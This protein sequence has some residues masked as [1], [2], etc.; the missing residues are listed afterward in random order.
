MIEDGG[1][2]P[3]G[4][5]ARDWR[6]YALSGLA[7]VAI[8]AVAALIQSLLY[9]QKVRRP[10]EFLPSSARA[11][12]ALDVRPDSP[13]VVKMREVWPAQDIS[14]LADRAAELS[15]EVVSWTGLQLDM[16][17]DV[18]PW[19]AGEIAA[20]VVPVEDDIALNP[21]SVVV[22]ARTSSLRRA[23]AALDR[24]V[25]PM[26]HDLE[27]KR[28]T[29]RRPGGTIIVWRDSM[30]Q[31]HV[32]YV[33]LDGCV[34]VSASLE[35]VEQCLVAASDPGQR[36]TGTEPFRAS[37]SHLP[38]DSVA[39]AYLD[40]AYAS[41]NAQRLLLALR[42]GWISLLRQI[43]RGTAAERSSSLREGVGAV[44]IA[45][46]PEKDGLRL[47]ASYASADRSPRKPSPT[48]LAGLA[49]LLP[50]DTAAYAL[51]HEPGR[52]L[53]FGHKGARSMLPRQSGRGGGL[54]APFNPLVALSE[55]PDDVMIAMLPAKNDAAELLIA[56]PSAEIAGSAKLLLAS[57]L[58]HSVSSEVAGFFVV[59]SSDAGLQR[60]RQAAGNE[61]HRL[62]PSRGKDCEFEVW[63]QA[64]LLSG[65]DFPL[66]ELLLRGWVADAGGEG[67][68]VLKASPRRLLGGD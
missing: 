37:F 25:K 8:I 19:F 23:R 65:G 32:A 15:K 14:H 36:L 28:F 2:A 58:P 30:R 44:A 29:A 22:I 45:A 1:S 52:F 34:I 68:V 12:I 18:A 49:S 11:A 9:P 35:A 53:S 57:L 66:Q 40:V 20:A 13:A 16:K 21:R 26:A 61:K 41:S 38:E 48:R 24:A 33:V 43:A 67:E 31:D 27:W 39:W 46:A 62:S 55:L 56:A 6:R 17:K 7:L 4:K 60:A 5:R 59:A 3:V 63:A 10:T 51:V 47:K 42:H 54:F 50:P 64:G